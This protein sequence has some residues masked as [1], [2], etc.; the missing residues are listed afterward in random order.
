[1]ETDYWSRQLRS[2]VTRLQGKVQHSQ[3]L[4]DSLAISSQALT[5]YVLWEW[6]N[7]EDMIYRGRYADNAVFWPMTL[8][9]SGSSSRIHIFREGE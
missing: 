9:D 6:I 5:V 4:P 3:P 2:S 8:R 7:A 1:M